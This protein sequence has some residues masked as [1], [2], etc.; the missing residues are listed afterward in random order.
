MP[1]PQG[2]IAIHGDQDL[3][4]RIEYMHPAPFPDRHIH[5]VTQEG[6]ENSPLAYPGHHDPLRPQPEGDIKRIP[7]HPDQP[8]QAIQIGADLTSEQEAQL[9]AVLQGNLDTFVWSLQ[10]LLG[11][12][13]CII[14]HSLQADPKDHPVYQGLRK[15]SPK[16]AKAAKEEVQKLLKAGIIREVIHSDWLSNTVL[17]KKRNGKWRMCIDFTSLIKVCPRDPYPLPRIDQLVDSNAS[18]ELLSF[19]DAY[20]GYH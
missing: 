14:E 1:K 8:Y 15:L 9:L 12:D 11:V 6:S 4:R 7:I 20:S 3:A 18:C 19:L 5:A 13:R 2:L 10:D 16:W 17:V